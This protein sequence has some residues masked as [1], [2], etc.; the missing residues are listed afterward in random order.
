MTAAGPL[1]P[2]E[3]SGDE[4]GDEPDYDAMF[5]AIVSPLSGQ[6]NWDS[7]GLDIPAAAAEADRVER[8]AADAARAE[9]DAVAKRAIERDR[10]RA[11]RAAELAEYSAEK[12]AI[13]AEYNSDDDHFTPPAPPPLPRLRPATIGA[14]LLM[15]AGIFLI[16]RPT[17]LSVSQELTIVLGLGLLVGGCVAL[18]SGMRKSDDGDSGAVL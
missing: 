9:E 7:S 2:G 18:I 6:M 12:A 3:N 1:Q 17:L 11:I 5:A 16:A 14:V 8:E 15:I 10:R 4:P 13:E